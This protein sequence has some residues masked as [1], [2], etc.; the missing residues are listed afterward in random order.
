MFGL[1]ENLWAARILKLGRDGDV[2]ACVEESE[3]CVEE[4]PSKFPLLFHLSLAQGRVPSE[5]QSPA[6]LEQS[7][8]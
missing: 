2:V 4:I 8:L 3:G 7:S 6:E 1:E 5:N